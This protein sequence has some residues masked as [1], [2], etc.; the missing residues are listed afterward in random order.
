MLITGG[1]GSNKGTLSF[2]NDGGGNG[3][4]LD[5][6]NGVMQFASLPPM[7]HLKTKQAS[8][9]HM[10][11][12]DNGRVGVGTTEPSSAFAVKSDTGIS[13]ENSGGAKWT[14]RTTTDGHLEFE[15]NRGGFFKVDNQGG[16]HLSRKQSKYKLEVDGTGMI[17]NGDSNGKAPLVFNP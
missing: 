2:A 9:V 5:Y 6:E 14:Y 8:K 17:L 7:K 1:A 12:L 4:Q 13:V 11:I 16:M 15:S 3:F 10:A